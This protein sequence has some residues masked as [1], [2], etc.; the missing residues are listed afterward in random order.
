MLP[1]VLIF[2]VDGTLA[3]T[4]RHGHRPAFNAAFREAKLDWEWSE[5]LYGELLAITGGKERMQFYLDQYRA[6]FVQP[7]DIKS[8]I[9]N[10]HVAKTRH[11]TQ[12]LAQGTI[13]LRVG[14][15]R[16]L[17]EAR[18][19]GIR[20]AIATTTTPANVDALLMNAFGSHAAAWFE[21]IAAGNDAKAKKPDPEIYR[22]VLDRLRVPASECIAIEDSANGVRSACGAG[23]KTL[24]TIN[25]YT[26]NDDLT[27]AA[28]VVDSLGEPSNPF[29]WIAGADVGNAKQVDLALLQR[30]MA[31]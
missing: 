5:D 27:G 25:D 3:D 10:L 14:V 4:E 21:I 9:A 28:V 30:L 18:I 1:S 26:R 7:P 31:S 2:D 16:L 8:I 15:R 20:L 12:M 11:F 29:N 19:A 22:V 24:V 6:D 23:I 17:D 13:P